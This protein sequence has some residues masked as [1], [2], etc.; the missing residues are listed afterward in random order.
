MA[1]LRISLC[2]LCVLCDSVVSAFR[3]HPHH[4]DTKDTEVAQSLFLRE[5]SKPAKQV[6]HKVDEEIAK[7]T[8][9]TLASDAAQAV[10]QEL[11]RLHRPSV[12]QRLARSSAP[13][14]GDD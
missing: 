4:R 12:C 11:L 1:Q 14:E 10:G 8:S 5:A 13:L 6:E 3:W 9:S 7:T 2:N